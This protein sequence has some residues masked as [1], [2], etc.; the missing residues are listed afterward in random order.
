MQTKID[1]TM[2]IVF[3]TVADMGLYLCDARDYERLGE[4][5]S[6][7]EAED[8]AAVQAAIDRMGIAAE[9]PESVPS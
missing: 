1:D 7:E 8:P 2:T 5:L 4:V 9:R 3:A 6:A